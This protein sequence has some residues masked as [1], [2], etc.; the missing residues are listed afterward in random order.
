MP[1][2]GA[3]AKVMFCPSAKFGSS[4][5]HLHWLLQAHLLPF[6]KRQR[7]NDWIP[8]R[9][10]HRCS[11]TA[12]KRRNFRVALTM[13]W[14][15]LVGLY[16]RLPPPLAPGPFGLLRGS[17]PD[18]APS[19]SPARFLLRPDCAASVESAAAARPTFTSR[20]CGTCPAA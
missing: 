17:L 7:L 2:S 15:P 5:H 14:P 3:H 13:A 1:F 16:L 6:V 9:F 4:E 20:C 10:L 18:A 8:W 11:A 12:A 19:A